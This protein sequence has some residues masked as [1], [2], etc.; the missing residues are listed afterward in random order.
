MIN[1]GDWLIACIPI[2]SFGILP[3]IATWIGGKPVEQSTGVALGSTVFAIAVFLIRQPELNS[4][5]FLV[6]MFSG[7]FWAIGSIGQFMGLQYLGVSKSI[8]INNG[9]QIIGTSLLGVLLGDWATFNAKV[10]GF[11]ALALIIAGIIFTSYKDGLN[12]PEPKWK[13]GILINLVS[14]LGFT[15]YIGILKYYS[16]DG[17]STLLPQSFGQIAGVILIAFIFF[18]KS[19]FT[20]FA[21]RNSIGGIIWAVGNIALLISQMK[22]GLAISYPISQAAVIV[23]VFGGVFI[24]KEYKSRKE[25]IA[26][27]AGMLLILGGL[28]LIYLSGTKD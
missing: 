1:I 28:F 21:F 7:L 2:L 15:F 18:R 17:W 10:Y 22:I 14:I 9:G 16:I 23:S 3:V 25:W 6:G 5:I 4:H 20:R 11:S 24:N 27:L 13:K 19:P 12:G 8:P 26:T